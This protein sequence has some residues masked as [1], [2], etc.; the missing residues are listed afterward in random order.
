MY[1]Y[2]E[3][4]LK[5]W[6]RNLEL[7]EQQSKN[8][9]VLFN[10]NSGG[11]AAQ[12]GKQ[13]MELLNI[14]YKGFRHRSWFM[15]Q[16]Y[17]KTLA[18]MEEQQWIHSICDEPQAGEGSIPT[19]LHATDSRKTLV[20]FH[21][22]NKE[23]WL[24]PQRGEIPFETKDDM[25]AAFKLSLTPYIKAGKLAMV[26]FQFPPWFDCKKENVN[27]LR[28]VKEKM[29]DIPCALEGDHDSLYPP[30]T[31]SQNKLIHYSSHFP[32]VE[33]DASFY[34]IQPERNN[35]KWVKETPET[36]QFIVK[37]YQG[38]TGHQ[39]Q[40]YPFSE[41]SPLKEAGCPASFSCSSIPPLKKE[42]LQADLDQD[43]RKKPVIN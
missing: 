11:D 24:R 31:S 20:R 2:N 40:L 36:F 34:A 13:M 41:E 4:E 29:G 33:L 6:K 30:K 37:A 10:N 42:M 16:F 26:L 32:I 1:L 43:F 9:Y 18:F 38:M 7:L 25:F 21:G 12:N 3:Q 17:D 39:F 22:R 5:D 14:E 27:Y 28:W 15:P 35:E 8:V 19:V 23:G